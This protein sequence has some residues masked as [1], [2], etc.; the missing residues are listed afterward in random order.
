[1]T[2]GIPLVVIVGPTACGK[3]ELVSEIVPFFGGEVV[4]ADSRKVYRFMEIGTARPAK[5]V[6]Q[7]VRFHLIDIVDPDASF[8][9]FDFKTKAEEAILEIHRRGGLPFLVGGSGLYV[10]AV[11]DGLFPG[12]SPSRK[13]RE[14]LSVQA[15]EFGNEYLYQRLLKVDHAA[16]SKIEPNNLRRIIRALE[17]YYQTGRPISELQRFHTTHQGYRLIMIALMRDRE[18]LYQRIN[19]RVERMLEKGFVEEVRGLLERGYSKDLRSMEGLG[20]R[21]MIGYLRGEYDLDEAERVI[22]RDTRRFAKRQ[23]TWFRRD[24]RYKWFHPEESDKIV[25]YIR[26]SL[27][28]E[29]L[30]ADWTIG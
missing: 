23:L 8:T 30:D 29:S 22:K 26:T 13:I 20:Y 10:R 1:M 3:T 19:L 27:N 14:E 25:D 5:E 12:P 24:A 7:K 16:A 9:A 17:V 15:A 11:I 4:S 2:K 18:E 6:F 21:Q 28:Q